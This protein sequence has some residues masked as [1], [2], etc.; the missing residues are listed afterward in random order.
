MVLFAGIYYIVPRLTRTDWPKPG[1]ISTHYR[2]GAVGVTISV[3]ALVIGGLK[4]GVALTNPEIPFATLS[5]G[6]VPFVGLSTLGL[7]LLFVGSVLLLGNISLLLRVS[8]AEFRA[9][10]CAVLCGCDTKKGA[11]P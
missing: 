3:V 11:K 10:L 6:T 7:I 1:W 2:L 9:N 4:Q 8:T 5:K